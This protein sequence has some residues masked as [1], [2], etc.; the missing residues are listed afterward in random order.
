MSEI[1]TA[2]D[3]GMAIWECIKLGQSV[4]KHKEFSKEGCVHCLDDLRALLMYG[5][6]NPS[7]R[8][9]TNMDVQKMV[10]RWVPI[11]KGIATAHDKGKVDQC[12]FAMDEHLTPLLSAPVKEIRAFWALLVKTLKED[13]EVP[14]F[15]WA[16]FEGW[17]E[18]ILA[19][20]PDGAVRQLKVE[21]AREIAEMVEKDVVPDLKGAI[22]GA[23][24]WRG[25]ETLT[26]V[27]DAVKAG[28]RARMVGR[29]SC[30]FLEV[31][32]E[33]VML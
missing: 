21:L 2:R 14:F 33:T 28:G 9:R 20:A 18:V 27:R 6:E 7:R 4:V 13:P 17:G 5:V 19:K 25:E 29:E 12:E 8:K 30:L 1:V 10:D 24:Q 11:V 23:L 31:D 32:G 3:A 22:A 16:M 15:V 26:K